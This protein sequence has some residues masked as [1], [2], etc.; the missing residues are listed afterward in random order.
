MSCH[1]DCQQSRAKRRADYRTTRALVARSDWERLTPEEKAEIKRQKR[2]HAKW[3]KKWNSM[4]W[5]EQLSHSIRTANEN[6]K[7]AIQAINQLTARFRK[8]G[9]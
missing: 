2:E 3:L 7:G 9:V 4:T 1:N 6:S 5:A 8:V